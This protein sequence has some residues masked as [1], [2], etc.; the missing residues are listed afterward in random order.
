MPH[1]VALCPIKNGKIVEEREFADTLS[2]MQQL[3]M[4]LKLKEEVR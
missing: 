4:E 2:L 1:Y 3:G